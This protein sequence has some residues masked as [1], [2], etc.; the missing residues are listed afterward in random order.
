MS[1]WDRT[2]GEARCEE[3]CAWRAWLAA[4]GRSARAAS[5]ERAFGPPLFASILRG[6]ERVVLRPETGLRV[7]LLAAV[8]RAAFAPRGAPFFFGASLVAAFFVRRDVIKGVIH[9]GRPG[10]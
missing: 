5:T 9:R 6:L 2:G 8:A 1:G 10:S 4:R 7:V 3:G